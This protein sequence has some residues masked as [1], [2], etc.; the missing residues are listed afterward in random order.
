MSGADADLFDIDPATGVITPTTV[1]DFDAPASAI[2]SNVYSLTITATDSASTAQIATANFTITITE[3]ITPLTIEDATFSINEN[4]VAN[5]EVGTVAITG[6]PT[7]LSITAGDEDIIFY[8]STAG[9]ITIANA[10]ALDRAATPIH[11]LTVTAS[12]DGADNVTK[13]ADILF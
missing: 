8:I 9:V 1:F 5:A 13:S 2:S 3:V 10:N 4:N 11:T 6:D 12:K 7:G